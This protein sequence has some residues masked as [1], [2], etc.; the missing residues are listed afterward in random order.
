V[1]AAILKTLAI[2]ITQGGIALKPFLPQLQ[3]T[4]V[5][6]LSDPAKAV[7][8]RAAKAL[9]LLMAL[10]PRVDPVVGDLCASA[11]SAPDAAVRHSMLVALQGTLKNAGKT[12][13]L[14][15]VASALSLDPSLPI[16]LFFSSL[17]KLTLTRTPHPIATRQARAWAKRLSPAW[18]RRSWTR[19][20]A[21]TRTWPRRRLTRWA[22]WCW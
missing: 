22:C 21:R 16:P 5:K 14:F 11:A 18:R 9:G 13:A 15:R 7:R 1:K 2:M 3:T 19:W 8:E 4:F 20:T 6:C 12:P 17:E 10:Q